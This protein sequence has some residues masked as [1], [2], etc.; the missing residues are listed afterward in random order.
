V[1]YKIIIVDDDPDFLESIQRGLTISGFKNLSSYQDPLEVSDLIEKGKDADIALIDITMPDMDGIDLLDLIKTTQPHTECIM[2]TAV[3]DVRIAVK[4]LKKGAYDY[5][6][7][8][9]SRDDLEA[10][11]NRAVEKKRLM[12]IVNISKGSTLPDLTN[13][14]AFESIITG[15]LTVQRILKEAELHA[16]SSLPILITGGSGTGKEL[17]AKAIHRAS[18]RA[19]FRFVPINMAAI[20]SS[21]FDSEFFGHTKGAFTGADYPREGYLEYANK[22]T[23]FLDEIGMME[24]EVQGRLLR[25]LQEGEFIPLGSNKIQKVDVRIISA[26]NVDLDK[27]VKNKSFRKDLYYR[28][29]GGW[30]HLPELKDRKKDI[31]LLINKFIEEYCDS[32]GQ[33]QDIRCSIEDDAMSYLMSYDYPGNIRELRSVVNSALNLTEGHGISAAVIPEIVRRAK[34]ISAVDNDSASEPF[35][36]LELIE[37]N[38]ILR[39]YRQ[40]DKNKSKTAEVLGIDRNTLRKKIQSYGVE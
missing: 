36:S 32:S 38:H 34:K 26:T 24:M 2:V 3:D 8:P 31:P 23:L 18:R 6:V 20:T 1:D 15:N 19:K 30:L 21:L 40:M 9:I 17:L 29:K 33:E 10:S 28:L 39:V 22:G 11:I 13:P 35:L 14:E 27:K 37:K 25:F 5:L 16:K 12:D 4:C 7:K